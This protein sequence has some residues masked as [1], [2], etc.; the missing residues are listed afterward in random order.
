MGKLTIQEIAAVL[1]EKNGFEKSEANKFVSAMF[2]LIQERLET[3]QLAKIKGFGTFKIIDVEARESISVR[4]GERVTI[5]GHSKVSFTPDAM[6]K[7]LVNKPF[8]QFET[9]VLND[10]VEFDDI[11]D[12]EPEE[13]ESVEDTPQETTPVQPL[14]EIVEEESISQEAEVSSPELTEKTMPEVAEEPIH[15]VVEESM[16]RHAE[17]PSPIEA[18]KPEPQEAADVQSHI[19]EDS[20]ARQVDEPVPVTS[21]HL[22]GHWILYAVLSL[23][24]MAVSGLAGYYYGSYKTL[25]SASKP[26]TV[27]VHDTV[28]AV[29]VDTVLAQQAPTEQPDIKPEPQKPAAEVPKVEPVLAPAKALQTVAQQVPAKAEKKDAK[30]AE[31]YDKYAEKDSRVRL[32]AYRI[33]GLSHEVKVQKGQTFYSICRANLG[34]DME[35][36]VEVYNNLSQNPKLKEGQVIKIPKLQLK[37]RRR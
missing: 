32:G 14:I 25:I 6:M 3:D 31:D 7:E 16:A 18:A 1:T 34:P 37:T 24:L 21:S 29:P 5:S 10:G 17:A 13:E 33:V 36:Y 22:M 12:E 4:T 23:L 26:D 15:E 2:A 27:V 19:V 35:C 30:P 28:T 11:K 9:V 20:V 8:S